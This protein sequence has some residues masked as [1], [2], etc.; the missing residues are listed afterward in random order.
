MVF[1]MEGELKEMSLLDVIKHSQATQVYNHDKFPPGTPPGTLTPKSTKVFC[2][3]ADAQAVEAVIKATQTSKKA[4]LLWRV[5]VEKAKVLPL[6]LVV[7]MKRALTVKAD[8]DSV[9]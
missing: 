6:A 9:L 3:S 8:V 2:P 5:R 7:W 1:E 4:G